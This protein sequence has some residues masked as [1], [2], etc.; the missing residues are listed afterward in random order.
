MV[1]IKKC[2]F[3]LGPKSRFMAQKSDFCYTTPILVNGPFVAFGEMLHFPFWGLFFYFSFPSYGSF[4]KKKKVDASK[5]ALPTVRA[6][7]ASNSPSAGAS[8]WKTDLFKL[9]FIY[10]YCPTTMTMF[11]SRL[12]LAISQSGTKKWIFG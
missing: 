6:L 7:S 3:F 1:S 8:R 2:M 4:R 5:S 12:F 11:L 10:C 9:C